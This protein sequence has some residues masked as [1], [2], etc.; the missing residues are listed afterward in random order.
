MPVPSGVPVPEGSELGPVLLAIYINDLNA[1]TTITEL[2][3]IMLK[4]ANDTKV[5]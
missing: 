4:F 2:A 5:G 3:S 1:G